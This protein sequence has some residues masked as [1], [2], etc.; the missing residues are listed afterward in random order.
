MSSTTRSHVLKYSATSRRFG[1]LSVKV[2]LAVALGA[3]ACCLLSVRSD[4]QALSIGMLATNGSPSS[5]NDGA[6]FYYYVYPNTGLALDMT[7]QAATVNGCSQVI[8]G[9]TVT[10]D[11]WA[12]T[13]GYL[14]PVGVVSGVSVAKGVIVLHGGDGGITPLSYA[15][16]DA[17]FRAGYEVVQIAWTNAWEYI[18]TNM[19]TQTGNIQVAACRPATVFNWVY[20]NLFPPVQ[21]ALGTAGMCAVGDSAGSS[22]VAYSLA[23]YG[24]GAW[25]DAVELVSGPVTSDVEQGC[26]VG[27]GLGKNDPITVCDPTQGN[28]GWGCQ[29][30]A[31]GSTWTLPAEYVGGAQTALQDWTNEPNQCAGTVNTTNPSN[32]DW[33]RE[34]IVDQSSLTG[35]PTPIFTYPKT[36][37][38][39]WLC[40]TPIKNQNPDCAA[41]NY[42]NPNICPNNSST[43]GQIFYQNIPY[44][45]QNYSLYAV[46]ACQTAEG[47]TAGNVPGYQPQVFGGNITG[48][49]AITYDLTGYA[50]GLI[51]AAC[52]GRH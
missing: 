52:V 4:A 6:G 42:G 7:C 22:A 36:A 1:N 9:Q 35:G 30:G 11:S 29:L 43:Q 23:Y 47:V 5:C 18:Y 16:A 33:L 3:V 13:I 25:F 32:T 10:P 44:G 26:G 14:N 15:L 46:D 28:K 12:L 2:S 38:S 34:S 40:R 51:S 27:T 19:G 17:Y 31:N 39:A 21:N 48:L 24:A 45:T 37:M 20:Q 41:N 8:N 50:P 49:L